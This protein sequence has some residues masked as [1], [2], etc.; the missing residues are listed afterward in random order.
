MQGKY[1][2]DSRT[3]KILSAFSNNFVFPFEIFV[4]I[5]LPPIERKTLKLRLY[6][7]L[8]QAACL[9]QLLLINR[10]RKKVLWFNINPFEHT[11][12]PDPTSIP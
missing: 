8:A 7:I 11:C 2:A 3:D 6:E 4:P 5:N 10:I 1:Q 9:I 12:Q